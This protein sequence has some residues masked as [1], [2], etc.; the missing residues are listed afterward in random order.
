MKIAWK[1]HREAAVGIDDHDYMRVRYRKRRG[2]G[3]TRWNDRKSR[4]EQDG[5]WFSPKNQG[6]NSAA[7]R[8]THPQARSWRRLLPSCATIHLSEACRRSAL[9][10]RVT[11]LRDW[12][13][14]DK[15]MRAARKNA[16]M[17]RLL[18]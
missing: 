13:A 17:A 6:F 8:A 16:V 4:I 12:L 3:G 2:L 5:A 10:P 14:Q 7:I 15:G 11:F 1:R 9:G 18:A